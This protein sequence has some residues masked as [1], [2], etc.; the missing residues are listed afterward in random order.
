[1]AFVIREVTTE[2]RMQT[3]FPQMFQWAQNDLEWAC[4]E[5]PFPAAEKWLRWVN[6]STRRV[7][8]IRNNGNDVAVFA[9]NSGLV[10]ATLYAPGLARK[11]MAMKAVMNW[12]LAEFGYL[13][14]RCDQ[15]HP[16]RQLMNDMSAEI[17]APMVD[18]PNDM[19]RQDQV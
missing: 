16:Y 9:F 14:V 4:M 18:L 11:K 19:M 15:D 13:E 12:S 5:P 2:N 7:V 8:V 3:L 6:D 17:G 10:V 1:M